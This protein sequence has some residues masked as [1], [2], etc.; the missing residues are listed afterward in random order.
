MEAAEKS[1]VSEFNWF[2]LSLL[3]V[4]ITVQCLLDDILDSAK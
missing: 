4:K 2:L 1:T 3:A